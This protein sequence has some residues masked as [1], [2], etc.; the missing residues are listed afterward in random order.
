MTL[1]RVLTKPKMQQSLDSFLQ[2]SAAKPLVAK[3][4]ERSLSPPRAPTIVRLG[5]L[6]QRKDLTESDVKQILE[7][8][9]EDFPQIQTMNIPSEGNSSIYLESCAEKLK[10]PCTVYESDWRRDGRR[11]QI[12]RDARIIKESTH[13][14]IFGAPRSEKPFKTAEQLARKNHAVFYMPRDS[15]ELQ[16]LEIP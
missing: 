10:I 6:G 12:F 8:I 2:C 13:Y 14:L 7:L 11:A 1:W 15:M 5:V 9:I 3:P 4:S 16:V